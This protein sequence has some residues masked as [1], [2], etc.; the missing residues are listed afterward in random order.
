V[1][2]VALGLNGDVRR[3]GIAILFTLRR[4]A[5]RSHQLVRSCPWG[6]TMED[7]PARLMSRKRQWFARMGL[8]EVEL[9]SDRSLAPRML[10]QAMRGSLAT[11]A[12]SMGVVVD[13]S[14]QRAVAACT[15]LPGSGPVNVK[16]RMEKGKK[17]KKG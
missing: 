14:R 17:G 6:D 4:S 7:E 13:V 12:R 5:K 2:V 3:N 1:S 8:Q 10:K 11:R 9:T 15:H 16:Q